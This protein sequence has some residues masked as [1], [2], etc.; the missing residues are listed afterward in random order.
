M[1]VLVVTPLC[2]AGHLP[3]EGGDRLGA[4]SHPR[5]VPEISEV[6]CGAIDISARARVLPISPLVGEMPGRAE[7]GTSRPAPCVPRGHA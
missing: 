5:Q 1:S 3:H 6:A 7:G 4:T 2:P